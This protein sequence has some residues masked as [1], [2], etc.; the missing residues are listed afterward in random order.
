[1]RAPVSWL[2]EYAQLPMDIAPR[3]LGDALV[4]VGLE[5][6]RVEVP[7]ELLVGPL[8]VGRVS[9]I[10]ALSEFKKPIRFCRLDVGEAEPRGIVCGASNFAEGDL[11]VVALPGA[12]LP[13]DFAIAARKTYGR[14]S[15]GMICSARELGLGDDHSGIIVLPAGSAEPGDEARAALHM[16]DAVLDIAITPDRGYCLSVRGLAREA[17]V[18]LRLPFRD[19]AEIASP[20][21]AAQPAYPVE[22]EDPAGCPQFSTRVIEGLDASAPTPEWMARRLAQCG[23]RSISLAVDVTNYVMLETGQPLHAFDRSKLSGALTARRARAGEALTTLDGAARTL[24]PDDLVVADDSGAVALA[25]VMG[26]ASTE[27]DAGTASIVLEAACWEAASIGRTA[28]R[29]KLPSEASKRF[30]RGVDPGIAAAALQRAVDL[31]V[32]HGGATQVGGQTVAGPGVPGRRIVMAADLPSRVAGIPID[33][34]VSIGWL[35]ALGCVVEA[36]VAAAS[37]GPGAP[38]ADA[39][40]VPA[41]RVAPP[42]WRPDLA[43]P[44]TLAEEVIRQIG[45][46]SLPSLL[47]SPP[48]GR[49]L[50][51]AQRLR[52]AASRALGAAGYVEVLSYP[53]VSAESADQLGL[54]PGDARRRAARLANPLSDAEP[55]MRT[56]LLPGL[57]TALG[58][59]IGRGQRDLALFEMGL[60]YLPRADAPAAPRPGVDRRPSD[61]EIAA[62]AAA[63]PDQPR[64]VATVAAGA[65]QHGGWWGEGRPQTW[66]DAVEAARTVIRAARAE[67]TTSAA[68]RAPWHPGRCAQLEVD[69]RVVGWAG[70]LHPAVLERL[71][72][73]PR[74]VAMEVDLDLLAPPAPAAAPA[75]SGFPPALLDIAVVVDAAVPVAAVS[76]ALRQGAGELLESLRLFDVF[77]DDERLGAG[78]K[79]LAFSLR[80]RAADRTLTAEEAAAARDGALA[81]AL[82]Q[83]GAQL[84]A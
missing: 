67:P 75:I 19:I 24:D 43:D 62:I 58:R 39:A 60:V 48:P 57:L 50:S 81:A 29:H 21:A 45:Y 74:T 63:I 7:A 78:R 44:A 52:R 25:G 28:R 27:V 40:R 80:L 82:A 54:E 72:L 64:H 46:E 36:D 3:A 49:G 47:P 77:V 6:E 34:D 13:G 71:G 70:E 76:Q 31:L 56:S 32:E 37:A 9:S 79:S 84:R 41:L 69:G 61:E 66:A 83:T 15:D 26:G 16:D 42:S 30:E 68:E 51:D 12:V 5:V 14:I 17:A 11:V 59:N 33:A 10:E 23:M 73:P 4:R 53:F 55:L 18:A 20:D 38:A 35:S 2:R 65:A 8:V 22:V 1:M